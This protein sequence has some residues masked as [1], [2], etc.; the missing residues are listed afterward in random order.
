[1]FLDP[2]ATRIYSLRV[3]IYLQESKSQKSIV[4]SYAHA[5]Q[6]KAEIRKPNL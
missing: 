2:W 5:P 4:I 3:L 6:G 1:M